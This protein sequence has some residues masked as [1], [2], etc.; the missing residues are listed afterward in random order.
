MS[1]IEERA[2]RIGLTSLLV[3]LRRA[4]A[5][6][7]QNIRDAAN[8]P[9]LSAARWEERRVEVAAQYALIRRQWAEY[10]ADEIPTQYTRAFK[11]SL[12]ALR[13]TIT[14]AVPQYVAAGELIRDSIVRMNAATISGQDDV[15][16]LFRRTQQAVIEDS[17]I[18]QR[19][20]EGLITDAT[21]RNLAN[22]IKSD[23]YKKLD[24]GKVLEINGRRYQV[25]PYAETVARTRTRE[26][27]SAGVLNSAR[28][29]NEDLIRISDHNTITRICQ[30]FEAKTYSI[31][32]LSKKYPMLVRMPPFHPRCQHVPTV[33]VEIEDAA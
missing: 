13:R 2:R 17:L 11:A 28:R 24:G 5:R 3:I 23:L 7:V 10:I 6:I 4:Q 18:S 29:L 19:L 31:S 33:R 22:I 14:G 21:P 30:E 16:L 25:G 8:D 1:T 27:Q 26:A 12:E 20:A 15:F 32:G 9:G